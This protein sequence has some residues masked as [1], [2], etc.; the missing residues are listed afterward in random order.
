MSVG[1][2]A[3]VKTD[4]HF[5]TALLLSLIAFSVALIAVLA[6]WP[7][8]TAT[9]RG[10]ILAFLVLFLLPLLCMAMGVSSEF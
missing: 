8:L 3:Y 5:P 9:R 7:R 10:K 6:A 4:M 1:A 2:G